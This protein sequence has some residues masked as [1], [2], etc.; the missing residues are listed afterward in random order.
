M[1]A[2]IAGRIHAAARDGDDLAAMRHQRRHGGVAVFRRPL[3]LLQGGAHERLMDGGRTIGGH[4]GAPADCDPEEEDGG[5][6]AMS[7]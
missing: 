6:T 4:E 2:R 1:R 5:D 7:L 3:R